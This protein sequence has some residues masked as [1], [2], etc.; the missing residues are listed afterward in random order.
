MKQ[1]NFYLVIIILL[2]LCA[3]LLLIDITTGIWFWNRKNLVFESSIFNNV[4]TP[5]ISFF[6]FIVYSGALYLAI[7]QNRIILSQNLKPYYENEILEYT[8]KA[9][10]IIFEYKSIN[11]YE[12]CNALNYIDFIN[13]KLVELSANQDYLEDVEIYHNKGSFN[14]K[15]LESRSY[16]GIALFLSQF[17]ISIN[18]VSFFYEDVKMLI[19]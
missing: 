5:T 8:Q 2:S 6:S 9:Q 16:Y 10:N 15:H 12:F 11:T 18:R 17:A 1:K 19:E 13:S 3:I 14:K 7:K 4:L